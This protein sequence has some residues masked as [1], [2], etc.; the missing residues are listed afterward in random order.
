M[1]RGQEIHNKK[2]I[3]KKKIMQKWKEQLSLYCF[4]LSFFLTSSSCVFAGRA[5]TQDEDVPSSSLDTHFFLC[6]HFLFVCLIAWNYITMFL[7]DCFILLQFAG[8]KKYQPLKRYL[9]FLITSGFVVRHNQY[10]LEQILLK[11]FLE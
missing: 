3:H 11:G 7:T 8:G 9:L 10:R 5:S 6:Y 2:V 4:F 1:T